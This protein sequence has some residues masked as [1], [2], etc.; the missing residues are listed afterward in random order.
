MSN[1]KVQLNL[2]IYVGGKC[3]NKMDRR[4]ARRTQSDDTHL[5]KSYEKFQ[6][7]MS[8]QV[9]EK[10]GKLCISSNLSSKR[11]ITPTKI[12]AN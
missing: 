8:K 7:I 1:F 11:G 2:S 9:E 6:L 12:D 3:R 10:C 5:T 4:R